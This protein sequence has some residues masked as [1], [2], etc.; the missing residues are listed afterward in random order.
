MYPEEISYKGSLVAAL[1]DVVGGREDL[2]NA[3]QSVS[4]EDIDAADSL[5]YKAPRV[6]AHIRLKIPERQSLNLSSGG[7][8]LTLSNLMTAYDSGDRIE[9][10]P[11]SCDIGTEC[12][13]DPLVTAP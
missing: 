6:L 2:P 8:W 7:D 12:Y 13:T 11:T 10:T 3:G 1:I 4:P 5:L 9:V